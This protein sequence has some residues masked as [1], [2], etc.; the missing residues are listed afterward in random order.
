MLHLPF[1]YTI[2]HIQPTE[3]FRPLV[4]YLR[5]LWGDYLEI[6]IFFLQIRHCFRI[7]D[8]VYADVAFI[9]LIYVSFYKIEAIRFNKSTEFFVCNK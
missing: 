1:Q 7:T 6:D 5:R 8:F 9:I 4:Q 2:S 3:S